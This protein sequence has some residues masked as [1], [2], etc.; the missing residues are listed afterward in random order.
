MIAI[1]I[2]PTLTQIQT[3]ALL[4]TLAHAVWIVDHPEFA[5]LQAWD[6]PT[7][8]LQDASGARG[9][10]TLADQAVVGVFFAEHS[11]R[12]PFRPAATL[13]PDSLLTTLLAIMPPHL[14]ALAHTET[15]PYMLDDYQGQTLP[16]ITAAF[17]GD[18]NG[19]SAAE[20]WPEVVANGAHLLHGQLLPSAEAIAYWQAEYELLPDQVQLVQSLLQQRLDP[21]EEPIILNAEQ[22]AVLLAGT[23]GGTAAGWEASRDL[24]AAIGIVLPPFAPQK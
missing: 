22:Q 15:L 3:G 23:A 10:V 7:Y 6:G 8:L 13:P 18:A 20:P 5:A 21:P 14:Q 12:N 19:I 4:G 2:F 17:W 24:L 1:D 16:M 9:A 11:P